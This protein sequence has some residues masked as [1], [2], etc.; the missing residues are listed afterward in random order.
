MKMKPEPPYY[1]VIFTFE[2]T[3]TD[4]GY[5]QHMLDPTVQQPGFL[6]LEFI[7]DE[8]LSIIFCPIGWIWN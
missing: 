8:A 1:T 5:T 2:W 3:N 7:C 4:S 6:G